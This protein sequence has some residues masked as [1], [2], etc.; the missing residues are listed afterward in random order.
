MAKEKNPW[1]VS[2]KHI[3]LASLADFGV[4]ILVAYLLA[5]I[6][7]DHKSLL[8][9]VAYVFLMVFY[10]IFIYVFHMSPRISTYTEHTKRF[11]PK[12]ELM[13]FLRADGKVILIVY[14]ICAIATEVSC[15]IFP[16][17]AP[18]PIATVT[19]FPIS[20][21]NV[22]IP[23]PVIRSVVCFVYSA[24][25]LCVLAL[26]RSHKIYQ[27]DLAAEARRRER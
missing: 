22:F 13:A 1:L 18:N 20:P 10:A 21:L 15:F 26:M 27:E 14:A 12:G 8:D 9:I 11:D 5:A 4:Y 17:P 25:V 7:E 24:V 3:A 19:M 6:F 23:V 16:S 2:L